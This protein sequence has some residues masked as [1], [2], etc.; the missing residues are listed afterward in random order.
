MVSGKYDAKHAFIG[1]GT[2]LVDQNF[3][4]KLLGLFSNADV[5]PSL[6]LQAPSQRERYKNRLCSQDINALV[7]H[8][9]AI[10]ARRPPPL[11]NWQRPQFRWDTF[12][13]WAAAGPFPTLA[14]SSGAD[15]KA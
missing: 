13:R 7:F 8:C 4:K 6:A 2:M 15:D 3:W 5:P 14:S 11:R 9:R 12:R 10:P 1:A